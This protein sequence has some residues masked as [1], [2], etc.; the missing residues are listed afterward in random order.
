MPRCIVLYETKCKIIP[1]NCLRRL[2]SSSYRHDIRYD[3][4]AAGSHLIAKMLTNNTTV[5]VPRQNTE[6]YQ[7]IAFVTEY[8]F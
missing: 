3:L 1:G 4:L 8:H 6:I 7:C 2:C 5:T